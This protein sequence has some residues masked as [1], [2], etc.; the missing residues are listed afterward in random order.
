MNQ[1]VNPHPAVPHPADGTALL[2][3]D[4]SA[5][6]GIDW[7]G[8][9]DGRETAQD[10]G[11]AAENGEKP[12]SRSFFGVLWSKTTEWR[13]VQSKDLD[14]RGMGR[15]V[16]LL[17]A[18]NKV[19]AA[20]LKTRETEAEADFQP[21]LRRLTEERRVRGLESEI[22][23]EVEKVSQTM[24]KLRGEDRPALPGTGEDAGPDCSGDE[25]DQVALKAVV[26]FGLMEPEEAEDAW[27]EWR[28]Q[29][30]ADYEP[31]TAGEIL[32]RADGFLCLAR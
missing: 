22:A 6:H 11:G 8:T 4:G 31:N 9:D 17:E 25:I 10:T 7:G 16:E 12:R 13:S 28:E 24:K 5:V 19:A 14:L 15:E 1:R 20:K 26:R 2:N 27:R 29:V 30:R 23:L 32:R 18:R 3:P 21:R